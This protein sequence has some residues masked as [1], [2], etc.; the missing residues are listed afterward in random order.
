MDLKRKNESQRNEENLDNFFVS[1]QRTTTL[2]QEK[3]VSVVG[4]KY[5]RSREEKM[6]HLYLFQ[7]ELSYKNKIGT[8]HH[9]LFVYFNLML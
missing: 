7:Y 8:N 4:K 6:K 1:K 3:Y 9:G 2:Q 5:S